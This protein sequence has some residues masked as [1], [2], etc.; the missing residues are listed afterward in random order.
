VIWLEGDPCEPITSGHVDGYVLV[1]PS[2]RVLMD[3]CEDE[4]V[5]P[6]MWREH[7]FAILENAASIE[8]RAFMVTRVNSPRQQYWR[9]EPKTLFAPTYLNAYVAN[10]LVIGARF[11]DPER[12][13]SASDAIAEAFPGREIVMLRINAVANGGGGVRC[14]TQPMYK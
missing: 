2:G 12:D 1:A 13:E 11:G 10:G 8:G 5:E 3:C 7:D 6:P 9:G 4:A 14:L